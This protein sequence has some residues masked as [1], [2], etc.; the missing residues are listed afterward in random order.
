ME[1][2]IPVLREADG[3]E[4]ALRL[5][6]ERKTPVVAITDADGRLTGYVTQEN[7]AELMMLEAAD[8]HRAR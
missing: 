2:E 5:M 8:W 1:R 4:A 3:L 7:V 6:Q